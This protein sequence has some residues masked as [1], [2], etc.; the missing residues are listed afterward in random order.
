MAVFARA[1]PC[2]LE[3]RAAG[4]GSSSGNLGR[5]GG[6]SLGA[7]LLSSTLG[8]SGAE[9]GGDGQEARVPLA[10]LAAGRV[11]QGGTPTPRF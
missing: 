1:D 3:T 8:G 9:R 10:R 2:S 11:G 6:W 4:E 5:R 7:G